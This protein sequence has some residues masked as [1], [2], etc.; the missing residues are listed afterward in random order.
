ML[1]DKSQELANVLV[2]RIYGDNAMKELSGIISGDHFWLNSV[3]QC[4]FIAHV[5]LDNETTRISVRP[6][7]G[8]LIEYLH[9]YEKQTQERIS[10]VFDTISSNE[11]QRWCALLF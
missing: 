7:R 9:V 4:R 10:A 8:S 2:V 5:P 1:E 6:I 3:N 11:D